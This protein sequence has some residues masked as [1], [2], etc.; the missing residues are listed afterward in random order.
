ML[1]RIC[2]LKYRRVVANDHTIRAG[3]SIL[4]LP[5][6]ADRRSYAGVRVELQLRLDARLVVQDGSRELLAV[7]APAQ[8]L[9]PAPA[10]PPSATQTNPTNTGSDRV[11]EQ[12]SSQ[13]R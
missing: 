1:E 4:Q 10:N 7:A 12:M 13:S 9:H 2:C 3:A 5:P 6:R 8:P 11:I